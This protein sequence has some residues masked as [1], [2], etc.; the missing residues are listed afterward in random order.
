MISEC[1]WFGG[2][3]IYLIVAVLV[4]SGCGDPSLSAVSGRVTYNGEPVTTGRISF[5]SKQGGRTTS[6]DL[7]LDGSYRLQYS[8]SQAALPVGEY[9]VTVTSKKTTYGYTN[10]EFDA[11]TVSAAELAKP[12]KVEWLV[13]EKYSNVEESGL[14]ATVEPGSSNFDFDLE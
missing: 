12:P 11:G 5:T 4:A 1:Y 6:G 13:P 7:Q 3:R 9:E 10:E 8:R 14:T 2:S